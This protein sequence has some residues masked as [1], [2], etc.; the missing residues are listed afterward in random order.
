MLSV[1]Q[2]FVAIDNILATAA[3]YDLKVIVVFISNWQQVD[4]FTRG[5]STEY[6]MLQ[7]RHRCIRSCS[8]DCIWAIVY[9]G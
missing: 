5:N 1:A 7:M 3:K 9:A 4:T 6:G 2:I 8:I